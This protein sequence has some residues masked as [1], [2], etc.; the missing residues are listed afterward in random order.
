VTSYSYRGNQTTTTDPAGKLKTFT[1]DAMENLLTV[2]EPDPTSSTVMSNYMRIFAESDQR[3]HAK[4]ITLFI[5]SDQ[6]F[7]E[8][9]HRSHAIPINKSGRVRTLIGM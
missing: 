2:T 1:N 4:A 5:Q 8:S 3:F 9:D 7:M 6:R